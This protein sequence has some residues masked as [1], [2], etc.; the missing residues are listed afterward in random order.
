MLRGAIIPEGEGQ[1]IMR[2]EP[3]SYQIGEN[4]SRASSIALILLLI[5]SAAGMVVS[6]RKNEGKDA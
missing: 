6:S 4:I 1:L 5:G 3:E 2:F